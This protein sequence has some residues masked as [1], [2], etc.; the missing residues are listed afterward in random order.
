MREIAKDMIS[1]LKQL[2]RYFSSQHQIKLLM[3]L[4]LT[5]LEHNRSVDQHIEKLQ[6]PVT[7]LITSRVKYDEEMKMSF[8]LASVPEI[9]PAF[10]ES[11]NAERKKD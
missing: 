2:Y 11:C 6:N 3:E 7:W 9:Y 1:E 8:V 4:I 5:K 10:A